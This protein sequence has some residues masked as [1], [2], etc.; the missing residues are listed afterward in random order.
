MPD[1]VFKIRAL[2]K[3]IDR[4][5]PAGKTY[6]IERLKEAPATA[7]VADAIPTT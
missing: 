5:S 3:Q 4:L 6:L 2:V 7:P 1:E